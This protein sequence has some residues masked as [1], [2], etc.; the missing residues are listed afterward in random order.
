MYYALCTM[1]FVPIES[2]S[3][4]PSSKMLNIVTLS[5][6]VSFLTQNCSKS[7]K[8]PP[9]MA[10]TCI[11]LKVLPLE[12]EF[13]ENSAPALWKL[14]CLA[15]EIS[16][17][18]AM[19]WKLALPWVTWRDVIGYLSNKKFLVSKFKNLYT[20]WKSLKSRDINKRRL[21]DDV[22]DEGYK[23]NIYKTWF[24]LFLPVRAWSSGHTQK[25][26]SS[27]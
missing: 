15:P 17:I 21:K 22:I 25:V 26:R 18:S 19:K 8:R 13:H 6:R 23:V 9:K 27:G 16:M 7:S 12:W 14:A 4:L 24:F 1:R 20:I 10:R 3:W 11:I 5:L 2:M